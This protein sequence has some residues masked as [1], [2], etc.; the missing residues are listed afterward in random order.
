MSKAFNDLQS[1]IQS[2]QNSSDAINQ[3]I[4]NTNNDFFDDWKSKIEKTTEKLDDFKKLSE[5][6]GEAYLGTKAVHYAYQQFKNK[7]FNKNKSDGDEDGNGEEDSNN[8]PEE[9]V[10]DDVSNNLEDD[11]SNKLPDMNESR[12]VSG[13][14]G[15]ELQDMNTTNQPLQT[16]EEGQQTETSFGENISETPKSTSQIGSRLESSEGNV[17]D[18]I[19]DSDPEEIS[20]GLQ[21]SS[22]EGISDAISSVN[23]AVSTGTEVASTV[24]SGIGDA[25]LGGLSLGL[26]ALGPLS[27]LGG[28]GVGLYEIFHHNKPK[29]QPPKLITASS[30]G[31]MV[32]PSYDSVIDTPASMSAF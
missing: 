12:D 24:G 19:L 29:P 11:V 3:Y 7:Y 9:T 17:Q 1:T 4:N 23:E 32:Q 13:E 10:E 16:R 8:T 14:S 20:S 31:E 22:G 18:K 30:R 26:E 5:N 25:V 2:Y 6:V 15:F 21:E 28:I 27:L